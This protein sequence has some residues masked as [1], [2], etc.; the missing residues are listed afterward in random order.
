MKNIESPENCQRLQ[1]ILNGMVASEAKLPDCTLPAGLPIKSRARKHE[2]QN[3]HSY[4]PK[5]PPEK[6]AK[7]Q[8]K[9]RPAP[10]M[11]SWVNANPK[12]VIDEALASD[13]RS[14][15]WACLAHH[16]D[17][18][19]YNTLLCYY[20]KEERDLFECKLREAKKYNSCMLCVDYKMAAL[21]SGFIDCVTC[22]GQAHQLCAGQSTRAAVSSWNCPSCSGAS[23]SSM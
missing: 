8:N 21:K 12:T 1:T 6:L 20:T 14:D 16:P 19:S 4:F 11:S 2:K 10:K 22:R 13:F 23:S 7:V 17:P 15:D 18:E 5:P 3:P 9:R